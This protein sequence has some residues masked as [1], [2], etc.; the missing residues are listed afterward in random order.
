MGFFS[1]NLPDIGLASCTGNLRS[2]LG[3]V[4]FGTIWQEY[5][6]LLFVLPF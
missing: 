4:V 1:K 3:I 5:G 6:L 2:D